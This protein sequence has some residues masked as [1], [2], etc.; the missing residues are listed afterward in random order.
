M[1]VTTSLREVKSVLMCIKP[2]LKSPGVAMV[3]NASVT[4]RLPYRVPLY[5]YKEKG[6]QKQE[7]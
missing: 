1:T 7:F 4:V 3:A 6:N 2:G 5:I